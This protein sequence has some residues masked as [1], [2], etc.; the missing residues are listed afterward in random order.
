M[1]FCKAASVLLTIDEADDDAAV[2]FP[3]YLHQDHP[4][5]ETLEVVSF[6]EKLDSRF[7]EDLFDDAM[8]ESVR[9]ISLRVV[10]LDSIAS[11]TVSLRKLELIESSTALSYLQYFLSQVPL[12]ES[13]ILIEALCS[14]SNDFDSSVV[15][16]PQLQHLHIEDNMFC[17]SSLVDILPCPNTSYVVHVVPPLQYDANWFFTSISNG[18]IL[19]CF[20]RFWRATPNALN[21]FPPGKAFYSQGRWWIQFHVDSTSSY[22]LPCVVDLADSML[23]SVVTLHLECVDDGGPR[24]LKYW[25][26][27]Y[28]PNVSQVVVSQ[29]TDRVHLTLEALERWISGRHEDGQPLRSIKFQACSVEVRAF[30]DRLVD[31]QLAHVVIWQDTFLASV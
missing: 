5:L 14:I 9:D 11:Y 21:N 31:A 23:S 28:L 27:R 22:T 7:V 26:A 1:C 17:V 25:P 10:G 24:W 2:R 19:G 18:I 3:R 6:N 15:H 4:L 12:L 8:W 13:L 30:C 16:L 20:A 29:L